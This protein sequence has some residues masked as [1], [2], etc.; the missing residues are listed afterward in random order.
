M[1]KRGDSPEFYEILKG[2]IGDRTKPSTEPAGGVAVAPPPEPAPT[3]AA[4][5]ATVTTVTEGASAPAVTP[6]PPV[7]GAAPMGERT[8]TIK[9][10]TLAFLLFFLLGA[11]FVAFALGAL[12]GQQKRASQFSDTL[13]PVPAEPRQGNLPAAPDGTGPTTLVSGPGSTVVPVPAEPVALPSGPTVAPPILTPVTPPPAVDLALAPMAVEDGPYSV[14]LVQFPDQKYAENRAK[15]WTEQYRLT[16]EMFVREGTYGGKPVFDVCTGHY[17]TAEMAAAEA[18][19]W[20]KRD[21]TF[22]P[23]CVVE[24]RK[25]K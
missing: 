14:C 3:I 8:I 22:K 18:E 20:Q 13:P 9:Y 15:T 17:A 11:L 6:A 25:A 7:G 2:T 1:P 10:D 12:W 24:T 4:T 5:T 16:S 23:A 19:K 21:T